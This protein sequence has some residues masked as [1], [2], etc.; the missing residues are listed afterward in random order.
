[1]SILDIEAAV[2]VEVYSAA[3]EVVVEGLDAFLGAFGD[4]LLVL[5]SELASLSDIFVAVYF[6]VSVRHEAVLDGV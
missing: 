3:L 4:F 5:D 6:A 1:M 2:G